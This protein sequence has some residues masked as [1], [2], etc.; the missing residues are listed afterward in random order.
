M[1]CDL[2]LCSLSN[3]TDDVLTLSNPALPV[4]CVVTTSIYDVTQLLYSIVP[5]ATSRIC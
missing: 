2:C 4:N 3:M 1:L 5:I